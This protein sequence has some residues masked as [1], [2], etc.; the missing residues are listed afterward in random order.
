MRA[1]DSDTSVEVRSA[2]CTDGTYEIMFGLASDWSQL[3]TFEID[4]NSHFELWRADGSGWDLLRSG[5]S[6]FLKPGDEKNLL[7]VRREGAKIHSFANGNLL[8]SEESASLLGMGYVGVIASVYNDANTFNYFDN[9]SILPAS[10]GSGAVN[11]IRFPT[12]EDGASMKTGDSFSRR[13]GK[14]D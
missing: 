10:C 3:Y 2:C 4:R 11:Q 6:G 9:F 1:T 12:A 13:P 14:T 5:N 8:L 7:M